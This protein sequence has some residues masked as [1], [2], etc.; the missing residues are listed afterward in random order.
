MAREATHGQM[1]PGGRSERHG[2]ENIL[3]QAGPAE[4]AGRHGRNGQGL[5]SDLLS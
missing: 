2:H 4:G 1:R 5:G 3:R